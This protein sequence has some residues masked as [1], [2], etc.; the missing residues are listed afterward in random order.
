MSVLDYFIGTAQSKYAA[1]A[2]FAAIIV[3]CIAILMTN[4]EITLSNRVAVVFFILIMSIFP[5]MIALFELTCIVTGGKKSPWSPCNVFAW[6]VAIMIV[7]Y[8]F[9]L[10]IMTVMS[11]FSYKKALDKVHVTENFSKMSQEQANMVAQNFLQENKDFTAVGGEGDSSE[12]T[13]SDLL[14]NVKEISMTEEFQ[15]K[16]QVME[17]VQ[18]PMQQMQS[19]QQMQMQQMTAGGMNESIELNGYDSGEN[20][21]ALGDDSA[22][23]VGATASVGGTARGAGKESY[24]SKNTTIEPEAF[25]NK[26]ENFSPL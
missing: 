25:S 1:I 9:I 21:M 11:M 7:V 4:T 17:P 19:M 24:M 23:F 26:I 10:I 22:S 18:Q 5:V 16:V 8:C 3:L 20:Y 6:F 13:Q 2:I 15:Q 14:Q 12:D